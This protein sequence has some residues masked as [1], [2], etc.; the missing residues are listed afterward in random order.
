[1]FY[2]EED[3]IYLTRGDDAALNVALRD[4]SGSSYSMQAGDQLVLTVRRTPSDEGV[5]FSVASGSTRLLISHE[6]TA[7][8]VT[9]EYSAD[10]QLTSGGQR[11]TVWPA[12]E[13]R[14]RRS[15]ANFKNFV[16]MPEVTRT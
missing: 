8:A 9:G 10:I 14:N 6:D 15:D 2:V 3:R 16:I 13:G 11:M 1:M 5:V 7:N 4:A 12:L